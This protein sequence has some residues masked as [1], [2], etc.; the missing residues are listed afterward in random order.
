MG[1]NLE[2][3]PYRRDTGVNGFGP[4]SARPVTDADNRIGGAAVNADN[5]T[6]FEDSLHS[7]GHGA[8]HACQ[9]LDMVHLCTGRIR[10][11]TQAGSIKRALP[12]GTMYP[13]Q[14]DCVLPTAEHLRLSCFPDFLNWRPAYQRPPVDLRVPVEIA[15]SANPVELGRAAIEVAGEA[16]AVRAN[17]GEFAQIELATQGVVTSAS[18]TAITHEGNHVSYQ[19]SQSLPVYGAPHLLLKQ[20]DD[21][22]VWARVHK[23]VTGH[24]QVARWTATR[25]VGRSGQNH[26]T[27][28]YPPHIYI[29]LEVRNKRK[30]N[31]R[32]EWQRSPRLGPATQR[33]HHDYH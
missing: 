14:P 22:A 9:R 31:R 21:T 1:A 17:L 33:R 4:R 28:G 29:S 8:L 15:N 7:A 5:P 18:S 16:F 26:S 27:R 20:P 12:W 30:R 23:L 2:L 3:I 19:L 10:A 24:L 6:S 32:R 11:A 25:S 13:P